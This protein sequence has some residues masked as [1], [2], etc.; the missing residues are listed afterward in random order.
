MDAKVNDGHTITENDRLAQTSDLTTT[1]SE[2]TTLPKVVRSEGNIELFHKKEERFVGL[3]TLGEGASG[4][5][6]LAHDKDIKRDIAI[7]HLKFAHE[8][9]N[10]LV[11]FLKEVQI[12]G[13]LDH[14]GTTVLYDV[15]TSESGEYYFMMKYQPGQT[16]R[17][18]IRK[19]Q[20]GD[21]ATHKKFPFNVRIDIF[22]QLL[23]IMSCAHSKGILHRD[24]KPSNIVIGD[25]GEVTIMD[26][27]IAKILDREN[28]FAD[29]PELF[30]P[31]SEFPEELSN[32]DAFET[33][34][35]SLLGTLAYMSPEQAAGKISE[36]DE[37]SDLFSLSA[38]LF[39]LLTLHFYLGDLAHAEMSTLW[40]AVITEPT[41][42]PLTLPD[43][44][45]Q[46]GTPPLEF[47]YFAM[48]GLQKDPS[49]RFQSTREMLSALQNLQA[50][51]IPVQCP[52]TF[53]RHLT[54]LFQRMISKSV[55]NTFA[56]LAV[57]LFFFV[58]GVIQTIGWINQWL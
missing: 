8:D 7:K 40:K 11:R 44:S 27:G 56:A 33:K 32:S 6:Y 28:D 17:E 51:L 10:Q 29:P 16:L 22:K 26:W 19:L 13:R 14:P 21:E 2:T 53:L 42:N 5:V 47:L 57:L 36:L 39:E 30:G 31:L 38:I 43:I 58:L 35:Q 15:G 24:L 34:E 20:A 4:K 12:T 9:N 50:G 55:F 25:Y 3:K 18:L 1:L 54:N 46:Q 52:I 37:R 41:V 48:K 49:K 23:Q 45:K